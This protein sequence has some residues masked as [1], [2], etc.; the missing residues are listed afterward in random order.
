[1]FVTAITLRNYELNHKYHRKLHDFTDQVER[2]L[3][4]I[5]LLLFGGS[6]VH[7]LMAGL[8]LYMVAFALIFILLVR[9][10]LGLLSL[11]GTRLHIKEK[12]GISFFGIRG[13]GSFYYLSFA[14]QQATFTYRNELWAIV[15]FIVLVS[16][17]IHGVTAT[18]TM[19]KL[20][21]SFSKEVK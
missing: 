16:I 2:M 10:L 4:A 9:P 12:M 14:L 3:V 17:V 19:E 1:V 20:E 11:V 18:R 5:V 7:G 8:D 15:S 13:I 21:Q 6:L